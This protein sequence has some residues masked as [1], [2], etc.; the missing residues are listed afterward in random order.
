[1]D[2][3]IGFL[4]GIVCVIVAEGIWMA[5]LFGNEENYT[6]EPK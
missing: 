6:E 5:W 1:M 4:A 2:F 3:F